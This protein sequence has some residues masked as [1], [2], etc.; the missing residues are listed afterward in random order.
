MTTQETDELERKLSKLDKE[1]GDYSSYLLPI[2]ITLRTLLAS[3][4]RLEKQVDPTIRYSIFVDRL[5]FLIDSICSSFDTIISHKTAEYQDLM[6][7]EDELTKKIRS[8]HQKTFDRIQELRKL[9][10]EFHQ[11]TN[12]EMTSLNNWIQSPIFDPDHPFGEN[13]LESIKG[14]IPKVNV[15]E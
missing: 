10:N 3:S 4:N 1:F 9:F 5:F 8:S 11:K 15:S 13:Y 12:H 6:T 7:Q 14:K 2:E